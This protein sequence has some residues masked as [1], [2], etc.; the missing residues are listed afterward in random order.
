VHRDEAAAAGD[1]RKDGVE[2]DSPRIH[3]GP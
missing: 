2:E 1:A 3:S